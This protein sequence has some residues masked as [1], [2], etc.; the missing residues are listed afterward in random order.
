MVSVGNILS[1]EELCKNLSFPLGSDE[2]YQTI[3][4]GRGPENHVKTSKYDWLT[5]IPV[6]ILE[7]FQRHVNVYFLF[8]IV[9]VSATN[10][11]VDPK[12]WGLSLAFI[13]FVTMIKQA[14]EDYQR[15][16]VDQ[17]NN[18]REVTVLQN[19]SITNIECQDIRVGELLFL[20][21]NDMV[22]ADAVVLSTSNSGGLCYTMTANLNGETSLKTKHTAKATLTMGPPKI[23]KQ[24]LSSMV[25]YIECENPNPNLDQFVGRISICYPE[26]NRQPLIRQTAQ[27]PKVCSLTAENLI[28]S[29]TQIKNTKELLC[30]CVYAGQETKIS[31]NSQI[32]RNKFSSIEKTYNNYIILFV[33]ILII[34][35]VVW[36][37]LSMSMSVYWKHGESNSSYSDHHWYLYHDEKSASH[38]DWLFQIISWLALLQIIPISLYVVLEVQKVI[39]R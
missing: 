28:L 2:K 25:S 7:Q 10:G 39:L 1:P 31:L 35:I 11:P 21:E 15:H 26:N 4:S 24:Y 33:V 34:Q 3:F 22:P 19:G 5:F 16:K 32:S 38:T 27:N 13:I 6:N 14:C 36:T 30:V 20:E 8:L 37:A 17:E 9:L 29:G 23:S 18:K 12:S